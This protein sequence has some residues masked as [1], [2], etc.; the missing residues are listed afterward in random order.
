MSLSLKTLIATLV[1]IASG[2]S[3][4]AAQSTA[5]DQTWVQDIIERQVE[6]RTQLLPRFKAM[7]KGKDALSTTELYTLAVCLYYGNKYRQALSIVHG[8]Q[9]QDPEPFPRRSRY[10]AALCLAQL[11]KGKKWSPAAL[12]Q[13]RQ[14]LNFDDANPRVW[15]AIH[16]LIT[17]SPL[18]N[19][20]PMLKG[21]CQRLI[22]ESEKR[23]D[24]FGGHLI[25]GVI[26]HLNWQ[27]GQAEQELLTAYEK[28]PK[29]PATVYALLWHYRGR[30]MLERSVICLRELEKLGW[31][32][33]F[34]K[35]LAKDELELKNL[36]AITQTGAI[37]APTPSP[38]TKGQAVYRLPFK[39]GSAYYLS[40]PRAFSSH[41]LSDSHTGRG[42]HA[43]D[44]LMPVLT[45][46][47]A[48]RDGVIVKKEQVGT[49]KGSKEF[50]NYLIV[51]HGDGTY[52]RYF[53]LR[54]G[55]MRLP[56]GSRV[57]AGQVIGQS[58]R[59]RTSQNAHLH[60]EVVKRAFW[61]PGQPAHYQFWKTIPIEFEELKAISETERDNRWCIS[62]NAVTVKDR[63]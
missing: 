37:V 48:A 18:R 57:R 3:S 29:N 58:E 8:L 31:D 25:S 54:S 51:A 36:M 1:I 14:S 33:R 28:A 61:N 56:K 38:E 63:W 20:N 44:F 23:N 17:A 22:R 49:A 4:L 12:D 52:A 24:H 10:L 27:Y 50:V 40:N 26:L 15:S 6:L 16:A 21:F 5:D 2:L 43:D 19:N 35:E 46:I 39:A 47:C 32:P 34:K 7:K 11:N 9:Q 59:T 62:L 53:H 45:P 30:G 41:P 13:L 55:S 60:F 42:E